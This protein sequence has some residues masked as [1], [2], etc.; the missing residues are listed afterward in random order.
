MNPRKPGNR[1]LWSG[2]A[3]ILR[4]L[5]DGQ[6]SRLDVM[7]DPSLC[8]RRESASLILHQ[9]HDSGLSHR[10]GWLVPGGQSARARVPV[11]RFGPGEDEPWPGEGQPRRRKHKVAVEMMSFLAAV[12]ALMEDSHHGRGLAEAVGLHP[13]TSVKIIRELRAQRLVRISDYIARSIGGWGYPLYG[14]GPD[15]TDKRKPPPIPKPVIWAKHNQ[16]RA[17]ARKRVRLQAAWSAMPANDS[18]M[19]RQQGAS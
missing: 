5:V 4:M 3:R 9:F 2:Y 16:L 11:Y 1:L 18:S 15:K 10:C 12:R 8:A 19:L 13:K 14:W 7:A 6:T 17:E